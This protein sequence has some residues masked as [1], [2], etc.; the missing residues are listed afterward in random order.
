M[1]GEQAGPAQPGRADAPARRPPAHTG[2]ILAT[3]TKSEGVN[4]RQGGA[5]TNSAGGT[6]SGGYG[7]FIGGA[8]GAVVQ[9]RP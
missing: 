7:V 3:N 5:V 2:L 6:I 4:L 1:S 9:H 8:G